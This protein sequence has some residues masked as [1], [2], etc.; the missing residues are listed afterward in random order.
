MSQST[1]PSSA[2][3]PPEVF[4]FATDRVL[5]FGGALDDMREATGGAFG[6]SGGVVAGAMELFP[7]VARAQTGEAVTIEDM[8]AHE[9]AVRQV[10]SFLGSRANNLLK[11]LT[12]IPPV[13]L[14]SRIVFRRPATEDPASGALS[15]AAI[16]AGAAAVLPRV[17]PYVELLAGFE[18]PRAAFVDEIGRLHA[19]VLTAAG[20]RREQF[21]AKE[22]GA[23]VREV[24]G[25]LVERPETADELPLLGGLLA[26]RQRHGR[27]LKLPP[28]L[29]TAV[30]A[31]EI[32]TILDAPLPADS[33]N[34]DAIEAVRRRP[35]AATHLAERMK[36]RELQALRSAAP[37][38]LPGFRD[39][40]PQT[41]SEVT[42]RF[43]LVKGFLTSV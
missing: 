23:A 30:V 36:G 2:E 20:D 9:T 38:L 15:P 1:N 33:Q 27:R 21:G 28:E 18:D 25:D 42:G 26:I 39:L 41:G 32:L 5:A 19:D 34:P 24:A 14:L 4:G 17:E 13:E 3:L 12:A 31:P 16:L 7:L 37:V 22:V 6:S 29:V 10:D 43:E 35:V 11:L 8:Q 40:L